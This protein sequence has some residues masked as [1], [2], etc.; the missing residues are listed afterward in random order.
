MYSTP[1]SA[2]E[3]PNWPSEAIENAI[4]LFSEKQ[5]GR[6]SVIDVGAHRGET[7]ESFYR[8]VPQLSY[9]GFEPNPDSFHAL[10]SLIREQADNNQIL[11]FEKAVGPVSGRVAFRVTKASEVCGVLMPEEELRSRVPSG[12]HELMETIDVDQVS[13]DEFLREQNI[14]QIDILKVDAEGYDL[15]VLLGATDA[16]RKNRIDVVVCEV[17]FV[18]YRQNQ[19][20][21][22]D[23]ARHLEDC[24]YRFFN[25][26]D[27]RN[28]GQGRLYTGN[29]VWVGPKMA[30]ELGFL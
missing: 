24:G 2:D 25:L 26:F 16:L 15:E 7:F 1:E 17:F 18:K 4:S 23:I 22:W 12:D 9:L 20:Y 28:T 11:C 6:L 21:F 8:S 14:E 5:Q 3:I 19:A 10:Q 29:G 13:L 30:L 27:T